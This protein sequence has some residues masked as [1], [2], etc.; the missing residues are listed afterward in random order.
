MKNRRNLSICVGAVIFLFALVFAINVFAIREADFMAGDVNGDGDIDS[1]DVILLQQY[2]ASFDNVTGEYKTDI[3]PGADVN[4]D[5]KIDISD[6]VLL[7]QVLVGNAELPDD[8]EDTNEGGSSVPVECNHIIVSSVYNAEKGY[9]EQTCSECDQVISSPVNLVL[10]PERIKSYVSGAEALAVDKQNAQILEENGREFYRLTTTKA[11]SVYF[12]PF[13]GTNNTIETGEYVIFK[14][15]L[16]KDATTAAKW[17]AYSSTSKTSAG[18][19]EQYVDGYRSDIFDDGEWHV[20]I[21][22]LN[23][24]RNPAWFASNSQGDYYVNFVR[25]D[26]TGAPIGATIDIEYLAFTEDLG[27]VLALTEGES[28]GTDVFCSHYNVVKYKDEAYHSNRCVIC[29]KGEDVIHSLGDN[30]EFDAAREC[31]TGTCTIC[32]SENATSPFNLYINAETLNSYTTTPPYSS[33]SGKKSSQ[34]IAA[35]DNDIAHVKIE[36]A[37][38]SSWMYFYYYYNMNCDKVTGQYFVIKYRLPEG[39][40][41]SSIAT[42][43]GS[44]T[45]PNAE[46]ASGENKQFTATANGGWVIEAIDLSQTKHYGTN[47]DGTYSAKYLRID[48]YLKSAID[49]AFIGVCD[50]LEGIYKVVGDDTTC[51]H[52]LNRYAVTAGTHE[53]LGCG[54]CK[55][56]EGNG[57]AVAHS[58]SNTVYNEFRSG[59]VSKCSTCGYEVVQETNSAVNEFF[60]SVTVKNKEGG[61]SGSAKFT[62]STLM[63]DETEPLFVRFTGRSSSPYTNL[64]NNKLGQ[65]IVKNDKESG[66]YIAIKYRYPSTNTVKPT[67]MN[68]YASGSDGVS[69]ASSNMFAV[70]VYSDGEWHVAIIDLSNAGTTDAFI[71]DKITLLRIDWFGW[72][73]PGESSS[74]DVAYVAIDDSIDDLRNLDD[75]YDT[76]DLVGSS[77]LKNTIGSYATEQ[78]DTEH[79]NMPYVT[80]TGTASNYTT[81]VKSN[82]LFMGTGKYVAILCRKNAN[83][84]VQCRMY[85]SPN[86]TYDNQC[87]ADYI[88]DEKWHLTVFDLSKYDF[89]IDG[90][91]KTVR[92]DWF[93]HNSDTGLQIDLAF[94]KFFH[95]EQEMIEFYGEYV[96]NYLDQDNCDHLATEWHYGSDN[97]PNTDTFKEYAICQHCGKQLDEARDISFTVTLDKVTDAKG[98]HPSDLNGTIGSAENKA[99]EFNA[100][101]FG[102]VYPT[103]GLI[104]AEGEELSVA[105]YLNTNGKMGSIW[106]KVLDASGSVVSA[107]KECRSSV[108]NGKIAAY[109]NF[110]GISGSNL[111]VIFAAVPAGLDDSITD[112]YLP[113]V[114]VSGVTVSAEAEEKV[115]F[116]ANGDLGTL[117]DNVFDGNYVMNETVMFLDYGDS[118]TLL[119]DIDRIISVKSYDGKTTYVEGVDYALVDGKIVLLEGS[120]IPCITPERYYNVDKAGLTTYYN[121]VATPTHYGEGNATTQW[122]VNVEYEH[123]DSWNGFVQDN[124]SDYFADFIEKLMNGEDVTIFYYGD[125]ITAG[126]NSSFLHNYAQ[127]QY[128]Y[129][130]LVTNAIADAFGYT[131][132]YIDTQ[133]IVANMGK[134]PSE[135]YVAGTRGTITYINTAVGGWKSSDGLA[136]FEVHVKN[137]IEKYGCDLFICAYGM[138]NLGTPY[139]TFISEIKGIVDGVYALA[140]DTSVMLISTMFRN[141]TETVSDVYIAASKGQDARL[142]TLAED[143][144][145]AGFE[146]GITHMSLMSESI[147]TR[148]DFM[149]YTGNN[150]NHP[151]DF[152]GRI[153]AQTVFEALIGYENLAD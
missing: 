126:A 11:G 128:S 137:Y 64:I 8:S 10:T 135:D 13:Q 39:V 26:F 112:R 40:S 27:N 106:F 95:T 100:T 121:G 33:V 83:T 46:A 94:V 104:V 96:K 59:Y 146:C 24:T 19:N 145:N 152:F 140:P 35:T 23:P 47:A 147:L 85:Y 43:V 87:F 51:M 29:G 9:Y 52:S 25:L 103:E 41:G 6:I 58:Y 98:S 88:S 18:S 2:F 82:N 117:M 54:I 68:I 79:N 141:N 93:N 150:V 101:N 124:Q 28:F 134:V 61:A 30:V 84:L 91:T 49:V 127:Q 115:N 151:N 3:A 17:S 111:T 108:T 63:G 15:R 129:S 31:Y 92:F 142:T 5:G 75:D 81:V 20:A 139:D 144:R 72:G 50:N 42:F 69:A 153:Y 123:S 119:Y 34:Y 132:H 120:S 99:I 116:T 80:L 7:R 118:K 16:S 131:V 110:D 71:G 14:Y 73:N 78:V 130:L 109:A 44:V 138:N 149:D 89:Y 4:K 1:R 45:S 53:D 37:S 21:I 76:W 60:S 48:F 143:Y 136:N 97:D 77:E 62:S 66:H 65:N 12:Y 56:T 32:G 86:N 113:I 105:G 74:V 90:I 22:Q 133:G 114:S 57:G 148:K 70:T 67:Y 125:S 38:S 55:K 122:Q 107:W 36:S 102:N